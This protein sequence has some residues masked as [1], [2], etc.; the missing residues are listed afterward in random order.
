MPTSKSTFIEI[1]KAESYE[2]KEDKIIPLK[3]IVIPIIQR[4][5]AQGRDDNVEIVRIRQRFLEALKSAIDDKPITLDFIYG[6]INEKGEMIPLDG[7]QR[8]TTLFLLHW[9]VAKKEKI[10]EE[11]YGFL[12]NFSYETRFST[13]DF[14]TKLVD[15]NPQFRVEEKLSDEIINQSWFPLEWKKD[16]TIK[17]MLRMLDDISK[18]FATKENVWEALKNG[19]ITFLFL[20]IKDMGLTDDIYIKMNSRGKT[21][22]KFEQ[23]KA[24]L[25]HNLKE[26]EQDVSKNILAKIDKQWTELLW[27]YRNKDN[28]VDDQF[29]RY[30]RFICDIICYEKGE[31]PQGKNNSQ[32]QLLNEYFS[33]SNKEVLENVNL[34]EKYLDCWENFKEKSKIEEFFNSLPFQKHQI[35]KTKIESKEMNLL[36]DCLNY[37]VD[38]KGRRKFTLKKIIRLYAIITYLINQTLIT[39]E[40]FARRLRIVDNLIMNSDDEITDS[41]NRIGGNRMPNILKQVKNIIENGKI[42]QSIGSNFNVI[43]LEQEIEKSEWLEKNSELEETLYELEDHELL[44]GQIDMIGLENI[45]YVKQFVSLFTCQKELIDGAL[46][47]IGNY[48]QQESKEWRYQLGTTNNMSWENLFHRRSSNKKSFEQTKRILISLLDRT[49][50]FSNDFLKGIIE[51][52]KKECEEKSL[53]D[54]RYYYLKYDIFTPKQYGKYR[55][56][57]LKNKPYELLVMQTETLVSSNTYQPFLKVID[58]ENLSKDDY[59]K[60]IINRDMSITCENSEYVIR[61]KETE[62]II[63]RVVIKQNRDGVDEEDRILKFKRIYESTYQ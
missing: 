63:Q 62:E 18:T 11:E 57:D 28:M 43:Q 4:D 37:Y 2:E 24:E 14:C 42:D 39:E 25:E 19:A 23:F 35:A 56:D 53:F 30:F 55:W 34:L 52:Y 9:Y 49:E 61:N 20:P 58:A 44:Y 21:L 7:Q 47:A 45:K 26:I 22:T 50:N 46:L 33:N 41:E 12:K 17:A 8:L 29:L 51:N 3:K 6:D 13:R 48:G 27:Q 32:F 1:F 15:F 16:P 31:T 10:K 5:Y 38:E 60:K 40:Q 54:W 59:G 36:E